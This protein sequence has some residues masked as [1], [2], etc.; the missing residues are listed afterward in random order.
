MMVWSCDVYGQG[1]SYEEVPIVQ[2]GWKLQER[3]RPRKTWNEAARA[4]LEMLNFTEETTMDLD[5][6]QCEVLEKTCPPQ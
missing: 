5:I 3:E 1:W 2:N 6:W 4:D